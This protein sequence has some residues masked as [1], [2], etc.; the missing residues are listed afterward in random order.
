M[1]SY[2]RTRSGKLAVEGSSHHG[3]G[4]D[5]RGALASTQNLAGGV[6]PTPK[7]R[8][9]IQVPGRVLPAQSGKAGEMS[10]PTASSVGGPCSSTGGSL[11]FKDE[12]GRQFE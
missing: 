8:Q 1:T 6:T 4:G 10:S 7:R 5:V 2:N 11:V 12:L 3:P 9:P